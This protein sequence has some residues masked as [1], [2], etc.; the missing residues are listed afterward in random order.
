VT[1]EIGTGGM[2]A[3]PGKD[4]IETIQTDTSNAQN[5]PVE[6]LELESPLRVGFL[7]LRR[8]SGGP[9]CFRGGLGFEKRLE[10][11][12][13][14][15][16]VSHRGERHSTAPWGVFGGEAGMSSRSVLRRADGTEQV[17]PSK[18]DFV[19]VPGDQLDLWTT[20]G[21]GYGDP[22]ERD[23]ERVLEDAIDDKVSGEQAE[24]SYGIVIADAAV[25]EKATRALR[26]RLAAQRGPVTWTYDR[27]ALGREEA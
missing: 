18:L 25:D 7:R 21:G 4:G 8:D 22:L 16:R 14:E 24:Q 23:P 17:I 26:R 13:G 1:A 5:I 20:G 2:G 11:L 3:R 6:A 15:L 19:M 9:G 12:R 27:G 10:V